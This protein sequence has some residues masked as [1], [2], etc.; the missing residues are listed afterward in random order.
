MYE[1]SFGDFRGGNILADKKLVGITPF[2]WLGLNRTKSNYV[3]F[4]RV[5]LAFYSIYFYFKGFFS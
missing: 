3:V 4:K 2:F 1:V 5:I